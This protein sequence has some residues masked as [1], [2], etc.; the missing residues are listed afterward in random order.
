MIVE[1]LMRKSPF[2]SQM[3]RAIAGGTLAAVIVSVAVVF[4]SSLLGCRT[5]PGVAAALAAAAGAAY[6]ASHWRR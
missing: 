3:L 4:G 5:P 2:Q 6:I 1:K